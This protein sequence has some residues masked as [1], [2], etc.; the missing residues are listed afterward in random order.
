[1]PAAI[2][3]ERPR[4]FHVPTGEKFFANPVT[5]SDKGNPVIHG[6]KVFKA[7]TFKDS[8]GDQRTWEVEHL[9]QMIFNFNLLKDRE[10]FA[11][12]PVRHNHPSLFGGGGEVI[13][14]FAGLR[15]EDIFLVADLEI[16]EPDA[17][18]RW[19][20]G[21][22]RA[23][24]LEVGAFETN[25][26]ALFWPTVM[27]VAF[28]D[29]GAVEGLF[30]KPNE[31]A[32]KMHFAQVVVDEEKET[33]VPG[34]NEPNGGG[35]GGTGGGTG[36]GQTPPS[37]PPPPTPTEGGDNPTGAPAEG[38]SNAGGGSDGGSGTNSG[39]QGHAAPATGSPTGTPSASFT[40]NGQVTT[41][42][43]AVQR[44][45]TA[46][47]GVLKD[48]SDQARKDFVTGLAKANK[49][50]ATQVDTLTAHALGLSPE[51][52]DTFRASY[53]AAP[54][55]GLFGQQ[56][57]N[58]GGDPTPASNGVIGNGDEDPAVLEERVKMHRRAGMSEEQVKATP[59]YQKL[60]ALKSQSTT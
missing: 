31:G 51:Q 50:A 1:M 32:S 26:E 27:G 30:S 46:M 57:D 34:E 25:D 20:R 55:V 41:D 38:G 53:E 14:Y 37:P 39:T 40:I 48:T 16:T 8:M 44:H 52:Y 19:E 17:F 15:R 58:G 33:S 45:I 49:I 22:Y 24:S 28:V 12:V 11:N 10:I 7:G 21:T 4:M 59:S 56:S 35:T 3:Q 18:A 2:T 47:E 43:A 60:Q 5:Q 29:I 36:G 9:E 23:R 42:F 54:Q 13:G 6:L